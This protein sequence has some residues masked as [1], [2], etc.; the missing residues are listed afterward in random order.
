[1]STFNEMKPYTVILE[2]DAD[3]VVRIPVP[4]HLR[5]YKAYRVTATIIT[6]T[7]PGDERSADI[8]PQAAPTTPEES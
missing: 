5:G 4:P 7:D 2:P 1:M 3:G 6:E 8:E